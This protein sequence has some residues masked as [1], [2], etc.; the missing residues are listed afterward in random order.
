M[1]SIIFLILA[2][3]L[4]PLYSGWIFKVKAFFGGAKDR[5]C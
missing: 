1:K 2:M 3:L 4:A 5:R